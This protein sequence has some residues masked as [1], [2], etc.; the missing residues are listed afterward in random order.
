[1]K[2]LM[3]LHH[4][5]FNMSDHQKGVFFDGHDREDVIAYRRDLLDQLDETT[6]TPST[7]CPSVVNAEKYIRIYRDESTFYANADQTRFGMMDN[8]KYCVKKHLD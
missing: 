6:I 5:G 7:P 8:H 2:Q 3:W 4:L 1:M